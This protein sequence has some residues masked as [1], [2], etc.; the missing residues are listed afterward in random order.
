MKT[1]TK[2]LTDIYR[3][4]V[5]KERWTKRK[6]YELVF[7]FKFAGNEYCITHFNGWYY[8][9]TCFDNED[10]RLYC[11]YK[12]K[13]VDTTPGEVVSEFRKRY[14]KNNINLEKITEFLLEPLKICPKP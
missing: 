2:I 14:L 9:C 12:Q 6:D 13:N 7:T 11:L 4:D 10:S 1:E 5:N 3:F 8:V